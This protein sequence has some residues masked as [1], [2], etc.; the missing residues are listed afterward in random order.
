[1]TVPSNLVPTA[2]S[3]LPLV[4]TPTVSDSIMVVQSGATYRATI[5]SVFSTVAVP[6]SR[7][8]ASGTG[9]GGGGDLAL[10]VDSDDWSLGC[11]SVSSGCDP[12]IKHVNQA[13]LSKISPAAKTYTSR[14]NSRRRDG[15][16]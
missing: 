13:V 16:R 9:L 2:I 4:N 11:R 8:I 3:Q 7:I 5:G 6:S 12:C 10:W 1:M 14:N 15:K